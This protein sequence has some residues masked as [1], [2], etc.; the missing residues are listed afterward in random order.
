MGQVF[1]NLFINAAEAMPGGGQIEFDADVVDIDGASSLLLPPGRYV[2]ALVTD[3]GVGIAPDVAA[4]VFDPYFTTK[5]RG[6]GLGLATV[7]SIVKRHGGHVEVRSEPSRG[8]TF[9]LHLPASAATLSP[10][11]APA[12]SLAKSLA[13]RVL[14][15]DDE[16]PVRTALAR[17]LA[18]FGCDVHSVAEGGAALSAWS[19]A[20]AAG[21]PFDV[22]ILDLTVRV[23]LGGQETTRRLR[24]LDPSA[25][26]IAS[27]GYSD[28]PVMSRYADYGFAGVASKPYT[29]KELVQTL[30]QVLTTRRS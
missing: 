9:T 1:S 14:V 24:E 16:E 18:A 3:H 25:L 5:D 28:S 12:G 29:V 26:V 30:T 2:R 6:S 13:A 8:S 27:S 19:A 15:M 23:G 17:I 11:E 4:R 22:A 10:E 20:R 7:H 21:R